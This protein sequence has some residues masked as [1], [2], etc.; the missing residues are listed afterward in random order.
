MLNDIPLHI[1]EIQSAIWPLFQAGWAK[2]GLT[3]GDEFPV[4]L[5]CRALPAEE[6]TSHFQDIAVNNARGGIAGKD[7]G[8]QFWAEQPAVQQRRDTMTD[9]ADR[10]AAQS[11]VEAAVRRFGDQLKAVG[12][13]WSYNTPQ[14][15]NGLRSS[16]KLGQVKV[17]GFDE[18]EDTLN[19]IEEGICEGTIVQQPFE[20]GYQSM[21]F[22]RQIFDGKTISVPADKAISVPALIIKK[23][24]LKEY[25]EKLTALR[26]EGE[27]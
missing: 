26:K 22:L 2:G 15:I 20:F 10:A 17:F 23:E 19:G 8:C 6:R 13:L 5:V 4:L 25:R 16:G 18:E 27:A 12:G 24:G 7:A 11:N 3:A 21:S 14:C 1:C 9:N